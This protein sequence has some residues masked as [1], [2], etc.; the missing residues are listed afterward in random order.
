MKVDFAASLSLIELKEFNNW[1]LSRSISYAL[2]SIT[3]PVVHFAIMRQ[4]ADY[5]LPLGTTVSRRASQ[6]RDPVPPR[7]GDLQHSQARERVSSVDDG[8]ER[9]WWW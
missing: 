5:L 9:W 4:A 2:C 3:L 6:I 7:N 1:V 8:L